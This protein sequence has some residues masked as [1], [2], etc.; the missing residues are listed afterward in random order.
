MTAR[1][2]FTQLATDL[3]TEFPMREKAIEAIMLGILTKEHIYLHGE[4]G[5][6]KSSLARRAL[7][8]LPGDT[9]TAT[10]SESRPAEAVLGP[11]DI[12]ALQQSRFIRKDAGYLTTAR[13]ALLDEIGKISPQLGH[14]LLAALNERLKHEVIDGRTEHPIP[15]ETAITTSNEPLTSSDAQA[16][17][18]RLLV[19]IDVQPATSL[20]AFLN[21]D[22]PKYTPVTEADLSS[23]RNEVEHIEVDTTSI[24]TTLNTIR[25][26]LLAEQ[27]KFS[28]R[29]WLRSINILKAHAWLHNRIAVTKS[30]LTAL[31]YVLW[32]PDQRALPTL[33]ELIGTAAM[34]SANPEPGTTFASKKASAL[35]RAKAQPTLDSMPL[36]S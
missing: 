16:L 3:N 7:S 20:I 14:D 19:R 29:R 17:W 27:I 4:P 5:T 26:R 30:D 25:T 24:L 33:W 36:F 22:T 10:L 11:Y 12:P 32:T 1:N 28:D 21:A 2:A 35:A 8:C 9:F 15:L 13:W 34:A 31:Q 23:A 18:D 6:A